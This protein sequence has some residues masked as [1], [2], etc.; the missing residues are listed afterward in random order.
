MPTKTSPAA[1]R[2]R[3]ALY[4]QHLAP[5]LIHRFARAVN[6]SPVTVERAVREAGYRTDARRALASRMFDAIMT[7]TPPGRSFADP[8][9]DIPLETLVHA[10]AFSADTPPDATE[11]YCDPRFLRYATHLRFD[12]RREAYVMAGCGITPND[13][14]HQTSGDVRVRARWYPAIVFAPWRTIRDLLDRLT[15]TA[16]PDR[17]RAALHSM[18][19]RALHGYLSADLRRLL[20]GC[21]TAVVRSVQWSTAD[22]DDAARNVLYARMSGALRVQHYPAA[23]RVVTV[24][25]YCC[26][27]LP[28][29]W[30]DDSP[31]AQA[32]VVRAMFENGVPDALLCDA[33]AYPP[34]LRPNPETAVPRRLAAYVSRW[35]ES[36]VASLIHAA[37]ARRV[38]ENHRSESQTTTVSGLISEAASTAASSYSPSARRV[39]RLALEGSIVAEERAVERLAVPFFSVLC[40]DI[41]AG[42]EARPA[43]YGPE[44]VRLLLQ[45]LNFLYRQAVS[46]PSLTDT[47]CM[48]R[49]AE[50]LYANMTSCITRAGAADR[51]G[52]VAAVAVADDPE[53][54]GVV[55][56]GLP[57]SATR[58]TLQTSLSS[59]ARTVAEPVTVIAAATANHRRPVSVHT[60]ARRITVELPFEPAAD[61]SD[62]VRCS[63]CSHLAPLSQVLHVADPAHRLPA[64]AHLTD[65]NNITYALSH[66]CLMCARAFAR[67]AHYVE[68]SVRS[69]GGSHP[70]LVAQ[71][72]VRPR[73]SADAE[74]RNYSYAPPLRPR[75]AASEAAR[76]DTLLLGVELEVEP[77][78]T[79][80]AT[81]EAD[82][83]AAITRVLGAEGHRGFLYFKSDSSLRNGFE[84]V[85]QPFSARWWHQ[86]GRDLYGKVLA[87]LQAARWISYNS[88]RCGMHVHM[89]RKAFTMSAAVRLHTLLF[90]ERR[91]ISVIAQRSSEAYARFVHALS[92]EN[93]VRADMFTVWQRDSRLPALLAQRAGQ[94][95]G[96]R[97]L[98]TTLS[99]RGA[100]YA[101]HKPTFELRVFRGTLHP[102]SFQKNVE[103]AIMLHAAA[104]A[105]DG[106]SATANSVVDFALTRRKEWP[107]LAAY[108]DKTLSRPA[109][110]KRRQRLEAAPAAARPSA[111]LFESD[112]RSHGGAEEM[113]LAPTHE[114]AAA[115]LAAPSPAPERATPTLL[116]PLT[117][118]VAQRVVFDRSRWR[119]PAPA[120]ASDPDDSIRPSLSQW[121]AITDTP[122]IGPF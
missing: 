116:R 88:P 38:G 19:T 92:D 28:R 69:R 109:S 58:A 65:D 42:I 102:A 99:V 103:T 77:S 83:R 98:E 110:D 95:A 32:Q 46:A 89:S 78:T 41:P 80:A 115:V 62:L 75:Y 86:T 60:P 24:Q 111:P 40:R 48:A 87:V 34:A 35:S 14:Y 17:F 106:P 79:H 105:V 54:L 101:S 121:S 51:P 84:I 1:K 72:T 67:T 76:S 114:E 85:S 71:R 68:A 31:G 56:G 120:D 70:V 43:T 25:D 81:P 26:P 112:I 90:A 33:P 47:A 20:P 10:I 91:A 5:W 94:R 59:A 73:E 118:A 96:Q 15:P 74:R 57:V 9:A 8:F 108:I 55:L 82:V 4:S 104:H 39:L 52:T 50:W 117:D 45:A 30:R 2:L 16:D 21:E 37:E 119:A 113:T 13:S 18:A 44:P 53:W 64:A 7:A 11:P 3:R 66:H 12:P 93:A 36:P 63:S 27:D 107:M 49:L 22:I 29:Q 97:R 23:V 122:V 61:Q 6:Q 100:V